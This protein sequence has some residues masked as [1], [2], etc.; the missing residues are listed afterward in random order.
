[1]IEMFER[2]A[3]YGNRR[4]IVDSSGTHSYCELM[5]SAERIASGLLAG[6]SSLEGARVALLLPPG[7]DFVA[8]L[9][10]I[11]LAGGIAV[12]LAT[13][14]PDGELRYVI[15]DADCETVIAGPGLMKR[16]AHALSSHRGNL[17]EAGELMSTEGG[18]PV[19]SPPGRDAMLL[20]TSGTTGR[21]KGVVWR[22]AAVQTQVEIMSEA[23]GWRGDDHAL[24]VLPLHHVHGLINVTA[25]ALWNGATLE[26]HGGFDAPRVWPRLAS[27]EITVFMAVPTIYRRLLTTWDEGFAKGEQAAAAAALRGMR[28]MVSGSAALP[29]PTLEAWHDISG[30]VLLERYGMTEIGMA[31]SN[32][33]SDDRIPGAVGTPLPTVEVRVVDDDGEPLGEGAPGRLQVRGPSVFERYWRRP[34]ATSESFVDEW[35]RTGDFVTSR[36]GVYR[37]LGRESV[38]IIKTG[39]EKVSALEIEDVLR[40]HPA[41]IDCAVVGLEDPDWGERV[42]VAAAV[43]GPVPSLAE[44]RD[45][46]RERL[47]PEKLPRE[48]LVVDELPRNALGKVLKP[49]VRARFD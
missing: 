15:N 1:M 7:H 40:A 19:G 26:M 18:P 49:E 48:L 35:F 4:A 38:D 10:G 16:A 8:A 46:C 20:Y 43:S 37:I 27:G 22:H 42:A 14:H 25:T 13:S 21:A 29:V 6:R 33:Y 30:H 17:A 28:L 32:S 44:L 41:I 23:W 39:G 5:G 24:L 12:P 45:F 2:A 11:W 36:S 34:E 31:L 47:A 9:W 3:R